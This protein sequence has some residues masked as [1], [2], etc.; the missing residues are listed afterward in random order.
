MIGRSNCHVNLF[1]NTYWLQEKN[2]SEESEAG[3]TQKN[4]TKIPAT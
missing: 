3:L 2:E 4:P 1:S